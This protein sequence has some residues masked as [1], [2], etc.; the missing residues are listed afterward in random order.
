MTFG[1]CSHKLRG[2]TYCH[3]GYSILCREPNAYRYG[4]QIRMLAIMR[5]YMY[6][7]RMQ[8]YDAMKMY[9]LQKQFLSSLSNR[10]YQPVIKSVYQ[11]HLSL[12]GSDDGLIGV[13][14]KSRSPLKSLESVSSQRSPGLPEEGSKI[15]LYPYQL[16][17]P[18]RMDWLQNNLREEVNI[19]ALSSMYLSSRY[20]VSLQITASL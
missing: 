14:L 9:A 20:H 16:G 12:M 15:Y 3:V 1:H 13:E 4:K 18:E 8:K 7:V 5:E 17:K 19:G 6:D 10:N 2:V 11:T